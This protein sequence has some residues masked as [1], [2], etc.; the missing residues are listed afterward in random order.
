MKLVTYMVVSGSITATIV[1]IFE[2]VQWG[3][4]LNGRLARG[5]V[6]LR[7]EAMQEASTRGAAQGRRPMPRTV[8]ECQA[9]KMVHSDACPRPF[10]QIDFGSSP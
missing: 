10:F 7:A 2:H 6:K 8:L 3:W 5:Q 4:A 1:C 9:S